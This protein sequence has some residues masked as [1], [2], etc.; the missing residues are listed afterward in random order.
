MLMIITE[1]IKDK[2][3]LKNYLEA[4]MLSERAS[5]LEYLRGKGYKDD[6]LKKTSLFLLR[7]VR[8]IPICDTPNRIL[9]F[10]TVSAS[11]RCFC[12]DN[13]LGILSEKHIIRTAMKWIR[14]I[15]L[16][17]LD[18]LLEA[19]VLDSLFPRRQSR[20]RMASAPMLAEREA[21]LKYSRSLGYSDNYLRQMAYIQLHI[22]QHLSVCAKSSFS[23]EEIAL[24]A[25]RYARGGKQSD[26]N[27]I[28]RKGI[29]IRVT[30]DWLDFLGIQVSK[31]TSLCFNEYAEEYLRFLSDEKN[32]SK[33][34][35]KGKRKALRCILPILGKIHLELATMQP[36]HIDIFLAVI[37]KEWS[38]CR[39]TL[40]GYI[41][42]LRSFFQYAATQNW[43]SDKLSLALKPPR[44][45]SEDGLPSAPGKEQVLGAVQF[46]SASDSKTNIRNYAIMI[47][48]SV[49]GIRTHELV[50]LQL[51][52]IDW[53]KETI[54]F[55][56]SKGER[57]QVFP[58][59]VNAGNAII[60]YLTEVRINDLFHK[61][62]FQCMV[63]PYRGLS[64]A[65]VYPIVSKALRNQDMELRHYGPYALRHWTATRL[66][67]EGFPLYNVS[68][69][70]G[71]ESPDSTRV[72]AKVN[73]KTLSMVAEMNWEDLL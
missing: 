61:S 16:S 58:L 66:I 31:S 5:Y 65:T 59:T 3:R 45:Y 8:I 69:Q 52:D 24:S 26:A 18:G 72:Y 28:Y 37:H 47:L 40:A 60:R 22:V 2:N 51:D 9:T 70:L 36:G 54:M 34:T 39:K 15:G 67:N 41:C 63:P 7:V 20:T 21:F 33:H 49:Y 32:Y 71:H 1:L 12:H 57:A 46:Y 48:L 10:E 30:I 44:L 6:Y 4:P 42:H 62:L 43:C 50:S 64:H 56:R 14:F 19:P 13:Q 55:R 23:E 35:I 29:F 38:I 11:I 53:D 68:R 17:N 73:M 25:K 27:T